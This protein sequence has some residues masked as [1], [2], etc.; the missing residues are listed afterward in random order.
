MRRP[1]YMGPLAG[2]VLGCGVA[3]AHTGATGIVKARMDGMGDIAAAAKAI[4]QTLKTETPDTAAIA[5]AA[6]TIAAL[7]GEALV[8]QF[9]EGSTMAPTEAA[10]AIW[11][12]P[13]GFADLAGQLQRR[14]VELAD[15]AEAGAAADALSAGFDSLH[16]TCTACHE[17]YRIK[18]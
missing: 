16:H 1:I 9:P 7:G 2:A 13:A 10:P 18:N 15:L 3:L 14:A 8:A 5:D 11:Q 17:R 12:D 4:F 6:R